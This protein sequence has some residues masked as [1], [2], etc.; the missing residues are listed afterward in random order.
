M[1][2]VS[3]PDS[4]GVIAYIVSNSISVYRNT[5]HPDA[6]GVCCYCYDDSPNA[7][8]EPWKASIYG[9]EVSE[10]DAAFMTKYGKAI[11]ELLSI[12]SSAINDL[13]CLDSESCM[14]FAHVKP[15]FYEE[16]E[17][18]RRAVRRVRVSRM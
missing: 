7:C 4:I 3:I 15:N 13:L 14:G 16:T 2:M 17:A 9:D 10:E 5:K 6:K 8:L 11:N 12:N 1:L 18:E